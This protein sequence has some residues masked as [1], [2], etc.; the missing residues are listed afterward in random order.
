M[1]G[2]IG[3]VSLHRPDLTTARPDQRPD[4]DLHRYRRSLLDSDDAARAQ[5][6]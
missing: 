1:S 2:A 4:A 6:A 3:S 5:A